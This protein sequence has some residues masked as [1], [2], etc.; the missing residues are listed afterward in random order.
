M[1][2]AIV[3]ETNHIRSC[4]KTWSL[5]VSMGLPD[6]EIQSHPLTLQ[7]RPSAKARHIMSKPL[8]RSGGDEFAYLIEALISAA[9]LSVRRPRAM[10]PQDPRR[11]FEI[12]VRSHWPTLCIEAGHCCAS[13]AGRLPTTRSPWGS[14]DAV[15]AVDA[16]LRSPANNWADLGGLRYIF[17]MAI[18]VGRHPKSQVPTHGPQIWSQGLICCTICTV[19]HARSVPGASGARRVPRRAEHRPQ[20]P[21]LDLS[22]HLP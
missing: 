16:P 12:C 5:G 21:D 8:P 15:F 6:P 20:N 18:F 13:Q 7:R 2:E 17:Y 14:P 3:L 1:P 10:K 4:R 22:F 19:F 11:P 9:R